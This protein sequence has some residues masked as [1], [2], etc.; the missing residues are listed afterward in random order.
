MVFIKQSKGV[1]SDGVSVKPEIC[2]IRQ[3]YQIC[4]QDFQLCLF[5]YALSTWALCA[6]DVMHCRITNFIHLLSIS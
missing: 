6:Q 2:L 1:L 3:C 5:T 4:Y